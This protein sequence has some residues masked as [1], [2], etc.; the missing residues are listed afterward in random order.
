MSTLKSR[1]HAVQQQIALAAQQANRNPEKIA[2]VA[3]TKTWPVETIL[4]AYAAGMRHFGENRAEELAAKRPAVE[5]ELGPD[6]GI[7][8]HF[9]GTLQ[10]RKTNL[11]ADHAD[12]FH[13][14]DRLKI[15]NRLS[16]RLVENGRSTTRPLPSFLEINISGEMSKSG[17]NCVDWENSAT[18]RA[19]IRNLGETVAALPGLTLQGIMTMAP[20]QADPDFISTV[21]K[22]TRLLAEWLAEEIG[23]ERP[24]A[25]SMGMTDDY[26]LA[27]AEGTTHVRV[28]R[29]LFG[30]RHLH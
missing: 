8:W 6:S 15:A 26:P 21:F 1:Y 29:A 14:L 18:Q 5:A 17:I 9:I 27:I 12:T 28:G 16:K 24:L 13:A 19:E 30:V 7:V 2:L 11:V 20:W 4:A 23:L 3:V 25:L 22:R 10:S